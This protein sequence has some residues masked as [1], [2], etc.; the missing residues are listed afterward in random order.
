VVVCHQE[1]SIAV[2]QKGTSSFVIEP[3]YRFTRVSK[4]RRNGLRSIRQA[5]NKS[6]QIVALVIK[7]STTIGSPPKGTSKIVMTSKAIHNFRRLHGFWTEL[8]NNERLFQ[9]KQRA[10]GLSQN[11]KTISKMEAEA[12]E[13]QVPTRP[14][15]RRQ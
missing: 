13:I 6:T 14:T 10:K 8:S 12:V 1:T 3:H 4:K 15:A 9:S 7:I 5:L 11:V 2:G